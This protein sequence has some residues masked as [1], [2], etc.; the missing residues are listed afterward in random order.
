[1][2]PNVH[3]TCFEEEGAGA[4]ALPPVDGGRDAW[5]ALAGGFTLEALVWGFPVC[6]GIFQT[7]YTTH[8][9]FAAKP[10]GIASIA[11]TATAIMYLG[12]P[13]VA[14]F[15]QRWPGLRRLSGLMGLVVTVASL[16][17]A[18]FCN[19]TAGLMATQGVMFALGGLFLYFPAMYVIDEWFVRRKGLA[20][21]VVW[22][23][24]GFSGAVLPW[25]LQWLLNSYGFR[26]TLRV[27]AVVM[28][29]LALPCLLVMKNRLPVTRTH[30]LRPIDWSFMKLP[31]FWFF[32]AGNI[33]MSLA[34]PLPNLYIPS[35]SRNMG[36]P[37]FSG[38]LA[39]CLLNIAACGGYLLQGQLVDRYH[40]TTAIFVAVA[41]SVVAVFLFWGLT[42]SQPMLYVFAVL[43]GLSGGGFA[44]NWA[45]CANAL[46]TTSN[47]LDT[48]MVISLMCAG[49]GI[50]SVVTG[51]ISEKLL[52]AGV[53]RGAGFAYGSQYGAVI[54]FTGVT[55]LL[56]GTAC[57]GRQ[58]KLL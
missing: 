26:T 49:K 58:L 36:M 2:L 40:V 7:Y 15:V 9:P 54:V 20:F 3:D 12:S 16:I 44:G 35:Y 24:T 21:G 33:M 38:P 19:S 52:Q 25:V 30:A 57:L 27:W 41:G 53:W 31:P 18:S 4:P 5:L 17:T 11:T 14:L 50:G 32:E 22:T 43:W 10:T 23:G 29:I 45:G 34:Y 13:F 6:Y 51:P 28:A 48:G 37:S 42:T 56:G 55:A 39:L 46:R 47:S 1:M 8:E